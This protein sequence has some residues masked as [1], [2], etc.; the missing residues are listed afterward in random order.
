LIKRIVENA[1]DVVVD[2]DE[3]VSVESDESVGGV[4]AVKVH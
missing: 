1:E 4:H 2:P 3:E